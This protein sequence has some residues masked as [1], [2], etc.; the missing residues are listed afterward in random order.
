MEKI[1]KKRLVPIIIGVIGVAL[2]LLPGIF[3]DK[4]NTTAAEHNDEADT[5]EYAKTL[6]EKITSICEACCGVSNVKVMVTLDG[7]FD[8][9]YAKNIEVG[10][11][12]YGNDRSEEYLVIG[13]GS[14]QRCV[15][16]CKRQPAIAGVGIVCRGGGSDAVKNELLTLISAALGIGASK[17]YITEAS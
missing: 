8:Y 11:G 7:G 17:I 1:T 10:N 12:S 3:G 5:L 2:I 14:N 4:E 16:I 9:E 13:Q 6:E 15:L